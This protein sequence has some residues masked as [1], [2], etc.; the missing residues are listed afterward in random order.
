MKAAVFLSICILLLLLSAFFSSAETAFFSL[1][2]HEIDSLGIGEKRKKLFFDRLFKSPHILLSTILLSNTVVNVAFSFLITLLFLEFL[3]NL[4]LNVKLGMFLNTVIIT[5]FLLIFGEF[6]PKFYALRFNKLLS[7]RSAI[8]LYYFTV[9]LRPFVLLLGLLNRGMDRL[10]KYK[11]K[12]EI[13]FS[14]LKMLFEMSEKLGVLKAKEREMINSLFNLTET[15]VSEVMVPRTRVF[16]V[17]A[18]MEI[19]E[20]YSLLLKRP[21]SRIPVFSSNEEKIEGVLYLKDLLLHRNDK[22]KR[23]KVIVRESLFV[24]ENMKLKDLFLD[25]RKK[26]V[27]FAIVVNEFG[28]VEGII[29]MHD[30]LEEIVGNIKDEYHQAEIPLYQRVS[31]STLLVDGELR[32]DEF[33]RDFSKCIP[34]GEYETV[35]GFVLFHLGRVPEENESF[36]IGD[37]VFTIVKADG[38]KLEK[39]LMKKEHAMKEK[40]N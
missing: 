13:S 18:D 26:R 39:I 20:V 36:R 30:I 1:T 12:E 8:P 17:H 32:I 35:G 29:T 24:T 2:E 7:M 3:P 22:K 23:V 27:H 34:Q 15:V 11:D 21:Y 6:T 16:S 5:T 40:K 4:R 31:K 10:V 38:K 33:P 25:F 37:L 19:R 28:G 14:E 9:L